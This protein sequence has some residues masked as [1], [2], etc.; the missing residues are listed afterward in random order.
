MQKGISSAIG[1]S[2][3]VV[4]RAYAF[5]SP[6]P[7]FFSQL[8][9]LSNMEGLAKVCDFPIWKGVSEGVYKKQMASFNLNSG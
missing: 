7:T 9:L 5:H 8:P 4:L 2:P 3:L 6:N 1:S